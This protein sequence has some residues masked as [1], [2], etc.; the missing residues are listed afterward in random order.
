MIKSTLVVEGMVAQDIML[1]KSE[2]N[3]HDVPLL[4][5]MT[6]NNVLVL[7]PNRAPNAIASA[8]DAIWT[9]A[10]NWLTIFTTLENRA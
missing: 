10:S 2:C 5:V 4:L 7:R 3:Y 6:S 9:P 8:A 1:A